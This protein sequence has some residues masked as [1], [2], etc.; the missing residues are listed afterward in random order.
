MAKKALRKNLVPILQKKYQK[1]KE[2]GGEER[3][4][5]GE[6]ERG[7]VTEKRGR[8]GERES[9]RGSE[10]QEGGAVMRR[11]AGK[12]KRSRKRGWSQR[13]EE[14]ERRGGYIPMTHNMQVTDAASS[15]TL[16]KFLEVPAKD[17]RKRG[18][19][20]MRI[21]GARE[22]RGQ[23]GERGAEEEGE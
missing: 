16:Q 14:M 13:D 18:G 4:G 8:K 5:E 12:D 20:R 15:Q 19:N 17:V 22:E 1:E 3:G 23:K 11:V 10:R 2:R 21:G 9:E 6:R 7:G